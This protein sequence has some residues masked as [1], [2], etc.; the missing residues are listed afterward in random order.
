M[1]T[2]AMPTECDVGVASDL[3]A[4][5]A[6]TTAST[7]GPDLPEA[8][9]GGDPGTATVRG[10]QRGGNLAEPAGRSDGGATLI[11]RQGG[12]TA[13]RSGDDLWQET[14]VTSSGVGG[15][16]TWRNTGL[17]GGTAATSTATSLAAGL[18]GGRATDP[19]L[20]GSLTEPPGS[21]ATDGGGE[22]SIRR[23]GIEAAG[24]PGAAVTPA[25]KAVGRGLGDAHHA[26][27]G[28]LGV[29]ITPQ[30][31]WDDNLK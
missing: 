18:A 28:V 4:S 31:R 11:R 8:D 15:T 20:T 27:N 29:A 16:V 10:A 17:R 22:P 24:L 2:G 12:E 23:R 14:A 30:P 25:S 21:L 5:V 13:H 9:G 6:A 1:K 3:F 7:R 26:A 19:L